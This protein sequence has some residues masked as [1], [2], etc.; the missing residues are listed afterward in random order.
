MDIISSGALG[1]GAIDVSIIIPAFN[2]ERRLPPFLV[3]VIDYCAL[4]K[5]TYEIIVVD[6]GSHD[7][8][9][10]SVMSLQSRFPR[11]RLIRNKKNRGKG[12]SI[13]RAI[14]LAKG[15]AYLYLDADG[16][17]GPYEIERNLRYIVDDG[18]DIIVGSRVLR[19]NAQ[20]LRTKLHRRLMGAVFNFVVR[21]ILFKGIKDTQCGF[22]IF[23]AEVGQRLFSIVRIK[24]FGFDIELLFLAYKLGYKIKEVPVSWRHIPGSKVNLLSDSLRML[25]DIWEVKRNYSRLRVDK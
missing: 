16:S 4:S 20:I 22:K 25:R 14:R 6:D 24:R 21:T 23:K 11:L 17:V 1:S 9:S 3:Q 15:Q 13:R 5:K 10:Q 7:N 19:D 8:T 12:F 18:F 2:E